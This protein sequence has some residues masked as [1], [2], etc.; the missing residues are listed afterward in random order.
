[1]TQLAGQT[2]LKGV[3]EWVRL[4]AETL[5]TAFGLKRTAMPCQMTYQRILEVID[6]E[7][8]NER[9]AAF[10]TRWEAQQRCAQEPSRLHTA[11]GHLEHA[12]VAIDGK[13]VQAT[14]QEAQP[15]HLSRA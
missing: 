4:R 15:G 13:T 11:S 1:M 8:L 7:A 3:T 6:P 14:S 5:A 9:L 10:F 12:Q 2:T